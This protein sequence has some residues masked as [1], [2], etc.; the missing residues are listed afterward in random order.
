MTI[1][2]NSSKR[3]HFAS[4]R[5]IEWDFG[6]VALPRIVTSGEVAWGFFDRDDTTFFDDIRG[7]AGLLFGLGLERRY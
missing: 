5:L 4:Q 7:P 1:L 2:S 3:A 6:E